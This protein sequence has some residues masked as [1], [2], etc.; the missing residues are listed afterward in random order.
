MIHHRILADE[1]IAVVQPS[2]PLSED[3][4]SKLSAA[5]DGY[6]E[7]HEFLNGLLIHTK[8]FPGWENFGGMIGHFRFMK[9][10]HERI[11]KVALVSDSKMA[12][13]AP[14]LAKHFV[15]ADVKS[16]E[17][18]HCDDALAWLRSH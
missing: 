18:D 2:A 8:A 13:L 9:N 11:K 17:F 3:D 4:F 14:R 12:S 7:T 6:L 10:H 15:S 1:A 5:V 16:F